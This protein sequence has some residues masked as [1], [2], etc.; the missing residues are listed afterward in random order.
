MTIRA[1]RL[2]VALVAGLFAA[3]PAFALPFQTT[4]TVPGLGSARTI[5]YTLNQPGALPDVTNTVYVVAF[6][7]TL[8]GVDGTSFCVDVL[9]GLS[10]PGTYN[11]VVEAISPAYLEA[12][13]IA[14]RWANDLGALSSSLGISL[15]DAAAGVQE[16]V[17]KSVYDQPAGLGVISFHRALTAGEQAAFAYANDPTHWNGVGSTQLL[18][19]TDASG[20][21]RQ[22]QLFTPAVPEPS[23]LLVFGVGSLLVGASLRKRPARA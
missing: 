4:G 14:N 5:K 15:A 17:W 18:R 23:A 13:Q 22:A 8:D 2:A 3:S 12:A 11:A 19:L 20:R 6:Q 21:I 1:L 16:A 10:V 9:H 7:S